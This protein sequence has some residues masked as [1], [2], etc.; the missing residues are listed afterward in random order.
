MREAV[1]VSFFALAFAFIIRLALHSY[2]EDGIPTFTFLLATLFI[3]WR[4]GYRWAIAQLV[5]GFVIATYF[6]VKPYHSFVMPVADDIYRMVYFF[7]VALTIVYVFEKI[8]RDQYEA[9]MYAREADEQFTQ[10]VQMDRRL[11]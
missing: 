7:C 6:F 8:R 5:A 10:L 11:G 3:S 2:L 4:Y 1:T 9:E